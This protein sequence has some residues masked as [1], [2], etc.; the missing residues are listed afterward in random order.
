MQGAL[1]SDG[2]A[3]YRIPLFPADSSGVGD[4]FN[5]AQRPAGAAFFSTS[6]L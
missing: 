4:A 5:G 6:G 3:M 2:E 1:P